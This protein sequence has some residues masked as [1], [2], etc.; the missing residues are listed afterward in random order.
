M[1]DWPDM[2]MGPIGTWPGTMTRNK[3]RSPFRTGGYYARET[4]LGDTLEILER[5]LRMLGAKDT[6]LLLAIRP[7]DFRLDGKPR[8]QAI[9]EHSGIILSFESKHGHLSYPCDTFTTWQANLRAIA[10]GLEALRKVT[11][12]GIAAH[13]QQYRGYLAIEGAT[14]MPAGFTT[15]N[16][17]AEWLNEQFGEPG[18][19]HTFTELLRR[20][21]RASHPDMG[22]NP[23]TFQRVTLAETKLREAG[24]L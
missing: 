1:S 22:G 15:A 11:R 16:G 20:A 3:Q 6:E 9:A 14:A 10:L 21:K 12:Y 18:T 8:A 19:I 7:Q 5:E 4:A 2:R 24:R 23:D 17:A 13:G